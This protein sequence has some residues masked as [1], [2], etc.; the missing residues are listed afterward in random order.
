MI[1]KYHDQVRFRQ[2]AAEVGQFRLPGEDVRKFVNVRFDDKRRVVGRHYRLCNLKG[3]TLAQLIDVGLERKT[4]QA[5]DR[6]LKS[7]CRSVDFVQD[8]VRLGIIDVPDCSDELRTLRRRIDDEPGV[9]R[10]AVAP[11]AGSRLEYGNTRM[12][13]SEAYQLPDVN[14]ETITND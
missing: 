2:T 1:D 14:I 8:P 9:D 11:N 6:C 13:V 10:D 7:L 3:R 5:N 4:K 12:T